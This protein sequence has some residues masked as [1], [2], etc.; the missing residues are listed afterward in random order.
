MLVRSS[1]RR[2]AWYRAVEGSPDPVL[3]L[4]LFTLAERWAE[5]LELGM[6]A[7]LPLE[8]IAAETHGAVTSAAGEL[9]HTA[10]GDLMVEFLA[11]C[12][13]HGRRLRRWYASAGSLPAR[14]VLAAPR[15]SIADRVFRAAAQ[16]ETGS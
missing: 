6:T 8:E 9:M 3:G 2:R 7:G 5:A 10:L 4:G 11:D 13:E 16:V 12:W 14:L 15:R 1:R